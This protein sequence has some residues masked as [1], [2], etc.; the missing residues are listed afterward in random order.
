MKLNDAILG[1]LMLALSVAILVAIQSF[2][3][4]PGQN[5]GP[6][7]FPGLLAVL[8]A[9]CAIA[10][11]ARGWHA[12]RAA[13]WVEFGSWLQSL[14]HITNFLVTVG[15]LVA[16]ILVADTLGFIITGTLLL[17]AMFFTLRVRPALIIPIAVVATLVI[18]TLFYKMLRVPLPWGVLQPLAW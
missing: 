11:I 18:H 15:S 9:G 6:A 10:L 12:R 14:P 17:S 4:I 13:A 1:A 2:P 8:L 3:N 5:I 16:Y 7:A